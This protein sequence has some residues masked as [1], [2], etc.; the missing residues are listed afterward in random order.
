MNYCS[1]FFFIGVILGLPIG[2]YVG[3]VSDT[4]LNRAL[5]HADEDWKV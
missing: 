3:I 4:L 1:L 5:E 2:V